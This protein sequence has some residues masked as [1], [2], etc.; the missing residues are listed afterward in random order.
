MLLWAEISEVVYFQ[1]FHFQA[2]LKVC[3]SK[4]AF[5]ASL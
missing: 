3:Q 1:P 2:L 5:S 4:S